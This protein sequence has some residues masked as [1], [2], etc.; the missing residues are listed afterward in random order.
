MLEIRERGIELRARSRE[1][2]HTA[3][4]RRLISTM[5][6]ERASLLRG[7]LGYI[8][9]ETRHALRSRA[10]TDDKEAF[11]L[12]PEVDFRNLSSDQRVEYIARAIESSAA[13]VKERKEVLEKLKTAGQS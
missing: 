13:L 8:L 1:L 10:L 6:C 12:L 7:K 9:Q 3:R 5:L 11:E 4:N 2:M